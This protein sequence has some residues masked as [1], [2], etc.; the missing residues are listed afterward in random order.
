MLPC[1]QR[2]PGEFIIRLKTQYI[3]LIRLNLSD[4]KFL[5]VYS[6]RKFLYE[7]L[8]KYIFIKTDALSIIGWKLELTK[9]VL[10]FAIKKRLHNKKKV[11]KCC[12]IITF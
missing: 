4:K 1:L 7:L 6:N 3:I 5:N 12:K 2:F 11:E 8:I 10:V 9:I